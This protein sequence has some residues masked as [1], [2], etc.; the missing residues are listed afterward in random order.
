M[1]ELLQ[2]RLTHSI[3]WFLTVNGARQ[4]AEFIRS[5]IAAQ[6]APPSQPTGK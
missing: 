4:D 6:A 1:K 5:V 3:P 2:Y